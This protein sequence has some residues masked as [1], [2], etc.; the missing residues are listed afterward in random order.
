[1]KTNEYTL[2]LQL[3]TAQNAVAPMQALLPSE[4]NNNFRNKW[5]IIDANYVLFAQNRGV[6]SHEP[7]YL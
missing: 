7:T 5:I 4:E 3:A 2:T 1:M 6:F